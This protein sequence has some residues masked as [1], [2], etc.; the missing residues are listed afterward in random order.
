MFWLVD[1]GWWHD[2]RILAATGQGIDVEEKR[3]WHGWWN[4]HVVSLVQ[5]SMEQKDAMTVLLTGRSVKG[6]A[7]L[8][9]RIC[10]SKKLEFDM[11]VLKPDSGPGEDRINTIQAKSAFLEELLNTYRDAEEVR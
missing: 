7:E 3:A 1:P 6:F 2:S 11:I 9:K 5:L 8:I 10:R 4:E